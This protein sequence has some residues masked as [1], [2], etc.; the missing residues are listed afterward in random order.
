[1]NP[2]MEELEAGKESP[3]SEHI[4]EVVK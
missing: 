2:S 3:S 1:M 4:T